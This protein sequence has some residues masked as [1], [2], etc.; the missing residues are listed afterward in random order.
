M[1]RGYCLRAELGEN[2]AKDDLFV[3]GFVRNDHLVDGRPW[4]RVT[5][6]VV[7]DRYGYVDGLVAALTYR[8]EKGRGAVV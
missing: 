4:H 3:V 7:P 1:Q 2:L 6:S 5:A 8:L